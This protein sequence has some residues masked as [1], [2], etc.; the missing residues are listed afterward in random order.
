MID[1]PIQTRF[2]AFHAASL[3]ARWKIRFRGSTGY[4]PV[5]PGC[6]PDGMGRAPEAKSRAR[7]ASDD[8][9]PFRPAGCRSGRASGPRYPL[10]GYSLRKRLSLPVFKTVLLLTFVCAVSDAFAQSDS[11]VASP[12][13]QDYDGRSDAQEILDGTDPSDAEDFTPVRLAYWKFNDESLTS[14]EGSKPVEAEGVEFIPTFD[15]EGVKINNQAGAIVRFRETES[16][17][18]ANLNC[19]HGSIRFLFRPDW[20]TNDGGPGGEAVF[21]QVGEKGKPGYWALRA[22]ADGTRLEFKQFRDPPVAGQSQEATS[23]ITPIDWTAG[24]W[25]AVLLAYYYNPE[26]GKGSS[27]IYING[28]AKSTQAHQ[29]W[30]VPKPEVRARGFTFGSDPAGRHQAKGVFDELETFNVPVGG[31]I[32]EFAYDAG[33]AATV[34]SSPPTIQLHWRKLPGAPEGFKIQ[35]RLLGEANWKTLEEDYDFHQW[36]F[37]QR[38]PDVETGKFYE[39]L[40]IDGRPQS[41]YQSAHDRYLLCAIEAPPVHVRGKILL[42]VDETLASRLKEDLEQYE[43]DLAGDGW[44]AIRHKVPRHDDRD[45]SANPPNISKIKTLVEGDYE[46]YG[47]DL[48]GIVII[49]HVAIPHSGNIRSID[50]HHSRPIQVDHYYGDVI[51]GENDWTD[52]LTYPNTTNILSPHNQP[53]PNVAGDGIF[54]NKTFPSKLELFV[55]RIDFAGLP[56]F[57]RPF[58]S[59]TSTEID[60]IQRYLEKDHRYRHRQLVFQDRSIAYGFFGGGF[61]VGDPNGGMYRAAIKNSMAFFGDDP[62]R[63]RQANIFRQ[64]GDQSYLWG[65]EFAAGYY[66]TIGYGNKAQQWTTEDLADSSKESLIGFYLLDGSFLGDWNR[67]DGW[68]EG[69]RDSKDNFLRAT[70][71]LENSGLAAMWQRW[72]VGDVSLQPMGLGWPLG[73]AVIHSLNTQDSR[74]ALERQQNV[75]RSILGDP[76]LRLQILPPPGELEGEKSESGIALR[77]TAAPTPDAKY[78]VYRSLH[79]YQG[80]FELLTPQPLEATSFTDKDP[81]SGKKL[82]QVKATRLTVTGS[83]SFHNLSQGIFTEVD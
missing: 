76:T 26:T 17:G 33:I 1:S 22:S 62:A 53:V 40:L 51:H 79:G 50:G 5:P 57:K 47:E 21:I 68:G 64:A 24:D 4:Q 15:G 52:S 66:D 44:S 58:H 3:K 20:S 35:R 63:I 31:K 48:K 83:G 49:G 39:Y 69:K 11:A 25:Y 59:S 82:Y 14:L 74:D 34:Q 19:R 77:W 73:Q 8:S 27:Q 80:P 46:K 60:L 56:A 61:G 6:Q 7:F 43:K 9:P 2:P 71:A 28:E 30:Y 65:F 10:F 67:D 72:W 18:S 78:Y 23:N 55:G 70:L 38:A 45:W 13:D 12:L 36:H 37:Q 16:D 41:L 42:L 81:P 32:D 54:D 29:V 75:H